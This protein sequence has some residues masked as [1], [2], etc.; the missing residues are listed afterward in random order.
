MDICKHFLL[1][2]LCVAHIWS[3][4][5]LHRMLETLYLDVLSAVT[6]HQCIVVLNEFYAVQH[7]CLYHDALSNAITKDAIQLALAR[8]KSCTFWIASKMPFES[9]K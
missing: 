3:G 7:L 4:K 9:E 2:F 6:L 8:R 1:S 5:E